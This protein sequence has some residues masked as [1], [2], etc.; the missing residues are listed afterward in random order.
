MSETLLIMDLLMTTT[1][2]LLGRQLLQED[3]KATD[4]T[5]HIGFDCNPLSCKPVTNF[6]LQKFE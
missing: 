3:T 4:P 5:I 2:Q 1:V 6:V